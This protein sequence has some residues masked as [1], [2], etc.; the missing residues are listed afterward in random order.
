M[1]KEDDPEYIAQ[2]LQIACLRAKRIKGVISN[3][4]FVFI[5]SLSLGYKEK[6]NKAMVD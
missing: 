3:N 6:F 5:R 4:A 2:Y 1:P